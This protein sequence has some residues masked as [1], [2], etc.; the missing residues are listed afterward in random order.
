[1]EFEFKI[2]LHLD[3]IPLLL[4]IQEKLGI[5]KVDNYTSGMASY[6]VTKQSELWFLIEIFEK[7]PLNSTKYL[8]YL[9]FKKAF[10]LNN[11]S[12]SAL[13]KQ[14]INKLKDGMNII[15]TD[16]SMPEWHKLRITPNGV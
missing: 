5:G 12:K 8:D 14:E 1:M 10:E 15:R 9:D 13:T 2:S 7:F 4:F 16:L 6:R 11:S 3:D